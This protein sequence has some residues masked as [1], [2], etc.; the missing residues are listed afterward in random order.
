M[1]IKGA[2][3][4]KYYSDLRILMPKAIQDY[5]KK[6]GEWEN[7]TKYRSYEKSEVI[8]VIRSGINVRHTWRFVDHRWTI[9]AD[10]M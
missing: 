10:S 9:V 1:A 2:F 4:G 8:T 3:D 5:Y 6:S 7:I